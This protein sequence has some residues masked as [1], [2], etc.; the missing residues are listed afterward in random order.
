MSIASRHDGYYDD[1]GH[2]QRTKHCFA[3]CGSRCT[4]RPPFGMYYSKAHDK[5]L[6]DKNESKEPSPT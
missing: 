5:S 4:C 3:S 1:T 2:W 6:K